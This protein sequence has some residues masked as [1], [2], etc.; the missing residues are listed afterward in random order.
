[1]TSPAYAHHFSERNLPFGIAS[2]K[3]HETPQAVT[4]IG[5]KVLFLRDLAADGLFSDVDGL[6]SSIFAAKTLN[7]FA[8][9]PRPIHGAV[10]EAVQKAFKDGGIA[11]FSDRSIEDIADVIMHLPVQI[12]DFSGRILRLD[13]IGL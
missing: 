9:L 8:A 12:G 10:R 5:N 6:P 4:R 1:M 13:R 11:A 2:S 7:E 3:T